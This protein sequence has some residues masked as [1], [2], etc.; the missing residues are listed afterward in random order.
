MTLQTNLGD[1][2]AAAQQRLMD[3]E[4]AKLGRVRAFQVEAT[5]AGL[6]YVIPGAEKRQNPNAT[7]LE[8]LI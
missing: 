8:L 5:D 4:R 3:Q 2:I 6:Q 7:Q 1:R